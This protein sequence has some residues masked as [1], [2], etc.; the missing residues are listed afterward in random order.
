M[1]NKTVAFELYQRSAELGCTAALENVAAMFA[2]GDGIPAN[3]RTA[4]Y[5]K[6][7]LQS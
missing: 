2:L 7:M 1:Q 6:K 4:Q 3:E 5:L